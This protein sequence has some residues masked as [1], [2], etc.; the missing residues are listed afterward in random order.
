MYIEVLKHKIDLRILHFAGKIHNDREN[1]E[2]NGWRK[3][4]KSKEYELQ[5]LTGK[6]LRNFLWEVQSKT[7]SLQLVPGCLILAQT[8]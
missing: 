1:V 3:T 6:M 5:D 7:K 8:M 4:G 2:E